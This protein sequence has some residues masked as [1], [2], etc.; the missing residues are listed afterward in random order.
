MEEKEASYKKFL[1]E[2]KDKV[3]QFG[4]M[5]DP[6]ESERFLSQNRQ[7][8][9]EHTSNFLVVWCIDL[10]MEEKNELMKSVASQTISMQFILELAKG[11]KRHPSECYSL[12]YRRFIEAK[13]KKN[14]GDTSSKEVE[15]FVAFETELAA[16]IDR[17]E[18]R[19][20]VKMQEMIEQY[21]QEEKEERIKASPCGLD[22]QEVMESLPDDLA[23]CFIKR[24]TQMLQD[25]L[26]TKGKEYMPYIENCVRSGLWVPGQDSPLYKL[27]DP[28]H[29][30]PG[31]VGEEGQGEMEEIDEDDLKNLEDE[32]DLVEE[33]D[34]DE[35][36]ETATENLKT[37]TSNLSKNAS[38][39]SDAS[40]S[41]RQKVEDMQLDDRPK[42]DALEKALDEVD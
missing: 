33:D 23:D 19:A 5:R 13:N 7:L 34:E 40:Q 20:K 10:E 3:K 22:P 18:K 25:V 28:N 6:V 24:D 14:S 9:C 26:A 30:L 38:T 17:V 16:F 29:K 8:I 31:E 41:I 21:E 42:V 36:M 11:I 15:Y 1:E 37:D 39:V 32:E 12:F 4:F 27:I 2:N 35:N